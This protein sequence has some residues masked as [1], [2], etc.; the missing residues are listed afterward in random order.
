MPSVSFARRAAHLPPAMPASAPTHTIAFDSGHASPSILPDLTRECARALTRYRSE[1]LQYGPRAGLPDL[2]R[3]IA[4]Y[5]GADGADLPSDNVLVTNGA[6]HAIE[7]VCRVL[8]DDGDAVVVTRPTYFSAIPIISSFGAQFLEIGQDRDGLDVAELSTLLVRFTAQRRP[9]PKFIYNVSDYHN[10]TGVTLS[11]QRRQALIELAVRY[12]IPIVDD[13]PYRNVRFEGEPVPALKALD[14]HDIVMHLGTFSKLLAP[15]LRVGWAAGA[16]ALITR[17]TYLK[18]DAGSC[19]LTQRVILEFCEAGRLAEHTRRVQE[20][21]RAQRD[22]MVAAV[23]RELPEV[24]FDV[25]HGGYYLWLTLPAAIDGGELAR[26]ATDAGVTILA[27]SRFF[28]RTDTG[29]PRNHA[30]IAFSHA[31][32]DEIEEGARRLASAYRS[33]AADAGATTQATR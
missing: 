7:L 14:P 21:Y 24:S 4:A 20:T 10:P 27:G 16:P 3:W 5:L 17:M 8:L 28:A 31:A 11:L 22:C 13:S 32:I 18:S 26:R 29:H 12:Q 9:L 2:R 15:G 25:P 6:K 23:R 1:T 19:P 33:C 30:R